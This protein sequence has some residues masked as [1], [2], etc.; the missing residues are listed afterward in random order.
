MWARIFAGCKPRSSSN[1]S[2]NFWVMGIQTKIIISSRFARSGQRSKE[3]VCT[4]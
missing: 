3:R 1:D 4:G 2:K